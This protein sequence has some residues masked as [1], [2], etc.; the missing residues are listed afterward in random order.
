LSRGWP[1]AQPERRKPFIPSERER[2]PSLEESYAPICLEILRESFQRIAG[3]QP[4]T[5]ACLVIPIVVQAIVL[6][7][8]GL[9]WKPPTPSSGG[10]SKEG[11]A[12]RC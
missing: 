10:S 5:F 4:H 7:I 11:G 12:E 2:L 8:W 3:M 9:K 6:L 1:L